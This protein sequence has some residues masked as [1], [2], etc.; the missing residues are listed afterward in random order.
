MDTLRA[1]SE[2]TLAVLLAVSFAPQVFVRFTQVQSEVS[3]KKIT[4]HD[5]HSQSILHYDFFH[6]SLE[7]S[8]SEFHNC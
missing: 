8:S 6:E 5:G 7:Y 4:I 3:H 1:S 2:A